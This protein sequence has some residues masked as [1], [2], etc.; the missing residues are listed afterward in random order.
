M[1]CWNGYFGLENN[2]FDHSMSSFQWIPHAIAAS[3]NM[4]IVH[5]RCNCLG[6]E[7]HGGVQIPAVQDLAK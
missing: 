5:G 6:G 2:F 1:H 4:E 3:V 7:F